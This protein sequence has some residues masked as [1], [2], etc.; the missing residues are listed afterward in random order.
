MF[1]IPGL[2]R[3]IAASPQGATPARL[4]V[5]FVDNQRMTG[6]DEKYRSYFVL[7]MIR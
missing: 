7:F 1:V 6:T 3:A 2:S 4:F 5:W